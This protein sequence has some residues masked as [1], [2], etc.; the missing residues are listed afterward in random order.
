M[1]LP[2][3]DT[4][5]AHSPLCSVQL[6]LWDFASQQ[7]GLQLQHKLA[8]LLDIHAELLAPYGELRVDAEAYS[9]EDVFLMLHGETKSSLK[10][11]GDY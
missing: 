9:E 6:D 10:V 5:R 7:Q 4:L 8:T 11:G 3:A 1:L 2:L